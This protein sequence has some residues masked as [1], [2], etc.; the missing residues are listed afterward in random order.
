M[1]IVST[2]GGEGVRKRLG[3]IRGQQ[4]LEVTRRTNLPNSKATL[5]ET[6]NYEVSSEASF[7][8]VVL[9]RW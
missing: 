1:K 3:L 6:K 7:N 9:R 2:A 8:A 4:S 5:I